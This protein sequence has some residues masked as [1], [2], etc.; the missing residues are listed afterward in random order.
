MKYF[1]TFINFLTYRRR[2]NNELNMLT[3]REVVDNTCRA[4]VAV[5]LASIQSNWRTCVEEMETFCCGAM[6]C[7]NLPSVIQTTKSRNC[8]HKSRYQKNFVFELFDFCFRH[9]VWAGPGWKMHAK[10]LPIDID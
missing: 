2:Q 10:F 4:T 9:P 3:V 7:D 1:S 5:T 8:W 6:N